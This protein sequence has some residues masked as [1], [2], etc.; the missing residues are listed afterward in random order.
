MLVKDSF[1]TVHLDYAKLSKWQAINVRV[2]AL[3]HIGLNLIVMEG[4][5]MVMSLFNPTKPAAND[6]VDQDY[7]KASVGEIWLINLFLLSLADTAASLGSSACS[8]R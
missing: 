4:V 8:F 6:N 1:P 2:S 3:L 7:T 5:I